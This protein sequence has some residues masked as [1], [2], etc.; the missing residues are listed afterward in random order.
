MRLPQRA[1]RRAD[2]CVVKHPMLQLR[3]FRAAAVAGVLALVAV[4]LWPIQS[5]TGRS[6]TD[7]GVAIAA[8]FQQLPMSS[9]EYEAMLDE[10]M[11]GFLGEETLDTYLDTLDDRPELG[12]DDAALVVEYRAAQGCRDAGR[13]HIMRTTVIVLVGAAIVGTVLWITRGR[14]GS[15]PAPS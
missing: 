6:T 1:A 9:A 8:S 3:W 2:R 13:W 11:G 5:T 7:C 14:G 4:F 12:S 10:L 15:E